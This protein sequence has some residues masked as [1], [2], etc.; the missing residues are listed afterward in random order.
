MDCIV[1]ISKISLHLQMNI[2]SQN[3]TV[4]YENNDKAR[5]IRRDIQARKDYQ[6]H[7]KNYIELLESKKT[8][9]RMAKWENR[10]T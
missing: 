4:F 10:L 8:E 7:L 1:A 2:K 6:E 3:E 9:Q 5:Q